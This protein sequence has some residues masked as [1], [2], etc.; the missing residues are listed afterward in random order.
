[1]LFVCAKNHHVTESSMLGLKSRLYSEIIQQLNQEPI[2]KKYKHTHTHTHT[3]TKHNTKRKQLKLA[4][5]A[6]AVINF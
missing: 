2:Q 3:H 4:Y 1:M 5:G 6:N